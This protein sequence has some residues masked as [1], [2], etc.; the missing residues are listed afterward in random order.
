[1]KMYN[2]QDLINRQ[3]PTWFETGEERE[4]RLKK[5]MMDQTLGLYQKKPAQPKTAEQLEEEKEHERAFNEAQMNRGESLFAIHQ[6]KMLE[7]K[8][9]KGKKGLE[10][11]ERNGQLRD[12]L[13]NVGSFK[14][15]FGPPQYTKG[16]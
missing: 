13:S 10:G 2:K 5:E 7:K 3:D 12:L 14:S 15:K 4:K 6:Q 11:L 8:G 9:Q 16:T 1:M